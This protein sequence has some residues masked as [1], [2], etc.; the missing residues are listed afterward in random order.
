MSKPVISLVV[1]HRIELF[2][3]GHPTSCPQ[4]ILRLSPHTYEKQTYMVQNTATFGRGGGHKGPC[5]SDVQYNLI[6]YTF[7]PYALE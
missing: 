5:D 4:F 6:F 7:F 1:P 2:E 3:P